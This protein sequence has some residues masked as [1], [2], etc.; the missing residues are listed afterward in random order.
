MTNAEIAKKWRL[1]KGY[2][3]RGG[4]IVVHDGV[5]NSW[6]KELCDPNHW[7]PGCVAVDELGNEWVT[8]GGDG[9]RGAESWEPTW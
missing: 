1:E 8:V 4:V 2:T 9:V 5:V 7:V 6:V 3:G